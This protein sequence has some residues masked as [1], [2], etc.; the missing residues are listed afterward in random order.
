MRVNAVQLVA[1]GCSEFLCCGGG[2]SPRDPGVAVRAVR[3]RLRVDAPVRSLDR[4]LLERHPP[5]DLPHAADDGGR[6]LGVGDGGGPTRTAGQEGLHRVRLRPAELARW[7]A[8]PRRQRADRRGGSAPASWPS[9]CAARPTATSRRSTA[10]RGVADSTRPLLDTYR[11]FEKQFPEPES[12][13]GSALHQYLVLR[14]G[15]RTEE[16]TIA[17]L[18][19]VASALGGSPS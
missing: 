15:I 6:R 16:G 8:T 19:E 18:D 7:I 4:L 2:P 9:N 12:L 1:Y 17:W 3:L 10:S 13:R 5:T 11:G 14:G